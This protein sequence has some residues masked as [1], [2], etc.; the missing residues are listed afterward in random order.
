M[1]S[2]SATAL[3]TQQSI[4]AY[5]DNEISNVGSGPAGQVSG[6][7]SGSG[8]ATSTITIPTNN[9]WIRFQKVRVNSSIQ[10]GD[11]TLTYGTGTTSTVSTSLGDNDDSTT[12]TQYVV[13]F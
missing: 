1:T 13:Y 6:S 3:A 5:V 2:D 11:M 8:S 7:G 9:G 12:I 4:K 10:Y